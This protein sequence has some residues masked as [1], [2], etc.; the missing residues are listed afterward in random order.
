MASRDHYRGARSAVSAKSRVQR[1]L[2]DVRR[3]LGR[4]GDE[5]QFAR[6]VSA[7]LPVRKSCWSCSARQS[8]VEN[9]SHRPKTVADIATLILKLQ[10][11]LTTQRRSG[12]RK[13]EAQHQGDHR[14]DSADQASLPICASRPQ[15]PT[16]T[17]RFLETRQP[18]FAGKTL[19]GQSTTT[20]ACRGGQHGRPS[21]AGLC[22]ARVDHPDKLF[23]ASRH[24]RARASGRS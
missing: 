8:G 24:R 16:C 21:G 9:G 1:N 15:S 3:P 22:V 7:M 17:E 14:P 4:Q 23:G 20:S 11:K 18:E 6:H 13:D 10:A 12:S 5:G 19:R 2:Q